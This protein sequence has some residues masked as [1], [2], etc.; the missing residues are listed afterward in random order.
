MIEGEIIVRGPIGVRHIACINRLTD[1][2]GHRF[3]GKAIVSVQNPVRLGE[4]SEPEPDLVLLAYRED[5]YAARMPGAADVLLL[6][7]VADATVPYDRNV[8]RPLYA[9]AAISDYWLINLV[10]D[11]IEVHRQ[12]EGERYR[13]M[14]KRYK[15]DEITAVAFPGASFP[16]ADLIP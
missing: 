5:F 7:E 9:R 14:V 1:L 6:I 8:K 2:L 12:P 4:R 15:G 10:D 11:V 13:E 16:V 3:R